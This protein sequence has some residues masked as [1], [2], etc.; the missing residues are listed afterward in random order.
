V[1]Y[2]VLQYCAKPMQVIFDKIPDFSW[3]FKENSFEMIFRWF[4]PQICDTYCF[5][6]H[7]F[8]NN[9]TLFPKICCKFAN[10][11]SFFPKMCCEF[12][13]N[14]SLFPK[15]RVEILN[16]SLVTSLQMFEWLHE[17]SLCKVSITTAKFCSIYW[18]NC[19]TYLPQLPAYCQ[20]NA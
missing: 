16:L 4:L 19:S 8:L 14:N 10:H 18:I 2:G 11:N 15:I 17:Y 12:S 9:N 6:P 7:D 5:N 13:S 3:L 1:G 20:I